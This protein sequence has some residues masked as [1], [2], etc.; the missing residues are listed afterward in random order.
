MALLLASCGADEPR[1]F[2]SREKLPTCGSLPARRRDAPISA[3]EQ[4]ALE[5]LRSAFQAGSSAEAN[6][7]FLTTEGDPIRFWIRI[8]DRVHIEM[9]EHSSDSF[10]EAG[11]RYFPSCEIATA[12]L[13]SLP[14]SETC[15]N[16]SKI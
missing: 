7:A 15:G 3:D 8:V 10:G 1:A 2:T 14:L 13:A 6:Y 9:Y 4:Q 11:W 12:D 5:C 16:G